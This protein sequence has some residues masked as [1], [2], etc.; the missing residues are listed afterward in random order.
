MFLLIIQ[1]STCKE[2]GP[3]AAP[4]DPGRREARAHDEEE[5]V[6]TQGK[7]EAVRVE[8]A[9]PSVGIVLVRLRPGKHLGFCK[10]AP[11]NC[12]KFQTQH[13]LQDRSFSC[14]YGS[15]VGPWPFGSDCYFIRSV[16]VNVARKFLREYCTL[17]A[18]GCTSQEKVPPLVYPAK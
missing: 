14:W 2:R 11:K 8:T 17:L 13:F 3:G 5:K 10:P 18:H 4:P 12:R 7:V 1:R 9:L 15:S 16:I 6:S